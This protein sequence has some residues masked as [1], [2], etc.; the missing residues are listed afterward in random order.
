MNGEGSLIIYENG[1]V[2]KGEFKDNERWNVIVFNKNRKIK[3]RYENGIKMCCSIYFFY[4]YL[5]NP[6][7]G[8]CSYN[9]VR[10]VCQSYGYTNPILININIDYLV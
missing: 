5:A 9:T 2:H 1:D 7:E 8:Y 4:P 6:G 3:F 10:T